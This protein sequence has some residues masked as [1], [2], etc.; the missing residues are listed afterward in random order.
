VVRLPSDRATVVF[1]FHL[2]RRHILLF[3]MI[4]ECTPFP[5]S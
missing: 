3:L 5:N 4:L 1:M 2:L